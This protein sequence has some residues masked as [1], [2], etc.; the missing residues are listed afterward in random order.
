MKNTETFMG[1]TQDLNRLLAE[2]NEFFDSLPLMAYGYHVD[3]IRYKPDNPL[4]RECNDELTITPHDYIQTDMDE[5]W[6]AIYHLDGNMSIYRTVYFNGLEQVQVLSIE[7]STINDT[8]LYMKGN[9]E[10]FN[11][12]PEEIQIKV[13]LA[14]AGEPYEEGN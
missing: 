9:D 1:I 7:Q 13:L 3:E 10:M 11:K 12:L 4:L 2:R 5:L 14:L 6:T 8:A